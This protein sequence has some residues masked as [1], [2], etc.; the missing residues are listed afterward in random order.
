[1]SQEGY[2]NWI[3]KRKG[4]LPIPP[5]SAFICT[6][7]GESKHRKV[8]LKSKPIRED[9]AEK[10]EELC[11]HFPEVFFKKQQIFWQN[12]SHHNVQETTHQSA[13]SHTR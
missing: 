7:T 4:V 12:K 6:P 9:T 1:M 11:E 8:K 5:K 10:F 2:R 3:P 13:R